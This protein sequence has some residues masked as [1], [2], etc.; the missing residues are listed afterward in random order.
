[1]LNDSPCRFML[2]ILTHPLQLNTEYVFGLFAHI[3]DTQF[4]LFGIPQAYN[5]VHFAAHE[6]IVSVVVIVEFN[7]TSLGNRLGYSEIDLW[8]RVLHT[9]CKTGSGRTLTLTAILAH[10]QLGKASQP[11]RCHLQI[12]TIPG[13]HTACGSWRPARLKQYC[14][15]GRVS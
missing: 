7:V 9:S 4:T 15:D 1:M 11:V 14:S 6:N 5:I 12:P 13:G 3:T 2:A 10:L 8:V